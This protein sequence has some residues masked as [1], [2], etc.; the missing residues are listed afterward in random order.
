[1]KLLYLVH[2]FLPE[3]VGGTEVHSFELASEMQRRGHEVVVVCSERIPQREDGTVL[4]REWQGLRVLEC[5]HQ[6][7]YACAEHT[8]EEPQARAVLQSLLQRERP[9][10]LHVQHFAQWGTAVLEVARE[11]SIASV[12][13]LH[14]YHLL[15]AQA[16]LLREDG[17][18]CAGDCAACLQGLPTPRAGAAQDALEAAANARRTW[19]RKHLAA[20][21]RVIAPSRFLAQ[22]MLE[23][24]MCS[25]QQLEVL[26]SG[27]SGPWRD[28]QLSDPRAPLRLAY[29]GGLYPN[30]G[31]H[32]LIEAFTR[33]KRGVATLDIHGVLEWFP[34]Y[35]EHLRHLC[36]G[37]DD[38]RWRGRF[39][40]EELDARL[41]T[42][43]VL[44]LP[45][46]WYE[47][48]PLT[49]QA[50]FRR[51]LCVVA[52]DLGGMAELVRP[53]QGGALFSRGD[54]GALA[55]LLS[56][57]AA[58]R[59]RVLALARARPPLPGLD[60]VA[61]RHLELYRSARSPRIAR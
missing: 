8:W 21:A 33:Q 37:R 52:S 9:D 48:R 11:L 51:G 34:S 54:V 20:A 35:V 1:M 38:V 49:L 15:C 28:P 41:D 2:D 12:V 45:S 53:G 5:V 40:P 29:V 30:K 32:V 60:A 42:A 25:A 55:Q 59:A 13:T 22:M 19:H 16:C 27:V 61:D 4:E 17:S 46:L 31:V 44:V 23:Q 18:L 10:V 3:H 24:R 58:D 39:A 7:E 47:N 57:L 6:R 26:A 50:A 56:E 43:D 14:D 36:A